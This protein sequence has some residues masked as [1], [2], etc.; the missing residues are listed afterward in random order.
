M[1]YKLVSEILQH[2]DAFEKKAA[3]KDMMHFVMYLNEQYSKP[4]A[5]R[6]KA[7]KKL[8]SN[9]AYSIE[10]SIGRQL[11]ILLKYAKMHSKKIL[12]HS[13]LNSLEEFSFMATLL[14]MQPCTKTALIAALVSE[15]PV[16]IE[17][18]KRLQAK[19]FVKECKIQLDKRSTQ[20][21]LTNLGE[22][23][24]GALFPEMS[25]LSQLI[26]GNLSLQEKITLMQIL[27]K[28]ELYH[29]DKINNIEY[30]NKTIGEILAGE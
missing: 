13:A 9:V 3:Q 23:T 24:L 14:S 19:A 4:D 10:D 28:L 2:I 22:K 6:A 7:T 30:K 26:S 15:K 27:N 5:K 21:E 11:V 20:I 25:Q 1:T 29:Q 17:I 12:D 18:I 16:G 8:A